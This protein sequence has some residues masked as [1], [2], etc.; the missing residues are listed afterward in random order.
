MVKKFRGTS[1]EDVERFLT[2]VRR[3]IDR[4]TQNGHYKS[5]EEKDEDYVTEIYNNCGARV[6][7]FLDGLE[8]EWEVDP[9]RVGDRLIGCYRT[10]KNTGW[11]LGSGKIDSLHQRLHETLG[12][13]IKRA[14]KMTG[15]CYGKD[16]L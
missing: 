3:G 14:L 9:D 8:G 13:Y 2:N 7:E 4:K 15:L 6:Q 5:D 10:L 11:D 16:E 1:G 12:H